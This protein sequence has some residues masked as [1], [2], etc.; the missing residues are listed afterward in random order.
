MLYKT[1]PLIEPTLGKAPI[2]SAGAPIGVVRMDPEQSYVQ[3]PRLL[4]KYINESDPAA[5]QGIRE[6]IDYTYGALDLALRSLDEATGFGEK[7]KAHVKEGKKALFKP[8]IVTPICIDPVTHG[9]GPGN[10]ACTPWAFI[11]AL[12]RW[13]H[14]KL[15]I[16]YHSMAVG[17]AGTAIS[18]VSRLFSLIF[19][20]GQPFPTEALFEG[21]YK[22]VY[23]GWGFYFARKY[24]SEVH[25][26]DHDDD[27]MSGY[28]ES[29]SG[30]YLP[31]GQASRQLMI[32]DLNRLF[33]VPSKWKDVVVPD[34]AN[35]KEITL[36]KVIVGGDPED[37]KDF[38]DYPGCVLVNVPRLKIHTQ[39]LLTNAVKNLGIG[40]YPME[41]ASREN[42]ASTRWKYSA[43]FEP[44]P[45]LKSEIP[46]SV[47][48]AKVDEETGLPLRDEKGEYLV[49]KTAGLSG[50]MVD[51]V[52]AVQNR[53]VFSVHVVD[54]VETVNIRHD[55][56]PDSVKLPEGYAL[57]A[58]DP[59]ALDLLCARYLFKMVPMGEAR[60]VQQEKNLKTDFLQRVPLPRVEGS[61]LVTTDGYDSPIPRYDLF[62]YAQDRGLGQQEYYVVGF[63]MVSQAPLASLEGHLGKIEGGRFCEL[64]TRNLYF[65]G[66]KILWDL[67]E[68]VLQYARANDQL[69]GSSYH[70][71]LLKAFDEDGDGVIDYDEMGKNGYWYSILRVLANIWQARGKDRYGFLQSSFRAVS[72]TLKFTLPQWNSHG[73]DFARDWMLVRACWLAFRMSQAPEER[74]DPLFPKL[75]WGKGKWPSLQFA[76]YAL[77]ATSLY[78]LEFPKRANLLSLY[79]FAFQ[80]ADKKVNGGKYTGLGLAPDPGAIQSYKE[81]TDKGG[82]L[83][84]FLVFVPK[85][86]G[87][88]NGIRLPNIQETED[89]D[90]VFTASFNQGREVW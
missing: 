42:P 17:E 15:K 67:Q 48:V 18:N 68:T 14:D 23:G 44:T 81:D 52:K 16:P 19:N 55:G 90:K 49:T 11:A 59:V 60:R 47:W 2:D 5:W 38:R 89:P 84:D 20:G 58:L 70:D 4:Q 79:G 31:P 1:D 37:A 41:A 53:G 54:A 43:P 28:E 71:Q 63:D 32:Y 80:Y 83:M 6:R 66:S 25:P 7:V 88:L 65:C 87:K 64:F 56:Y 33:D 35:F 29:L 62:R 46:H 34:G 40:L 50:T 77:G 10:P 21:R 45:T 30:T 76:Q 69:T 86:Y 61:N 73:H 26:R 9:E 82:A 8:N 74:K 75:T 39:A 13:F 78:G 27:P 36:H 12:M 3:I 24:L 51:I 22:N 57:A 85:G 72:Q